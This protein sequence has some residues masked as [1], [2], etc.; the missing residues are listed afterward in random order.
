MIG[1]L[2]LIRRQVVLDLV[3]I[4]SSVAGHLCG[5][6]AGK[7]AGVLFACVVTLSTSG[8]T[9]RWTVSFPLAPVV[10]LHAAEYLI[11]WYLP[12]YTWGNSSLWLLINIPSLLC[13]TFSSTL[14]VLFPAVELP[15]IPHAVYGV[16]V[17]D[18]YIPMLVQQHDGKV[19]EQQLPA[20]LLYPTDT[21][22]YSGSIPY[23][24]IQSAKEFCLS[25]VKFGAPPPLRKH[26]WILHNWMLI[27]LRAVPDAPPAQNV[28]NAPF[29]VCSH[30]LGGCID[31]Y[32]YQL[33]ALTARLGAVVLTF[34]HMDGSA[35]CIPLQSG[36]VIVREHIPDKDAV[37]T[38]RKQTNVRV[39]ELLL[40]TDYVLQ[41]KDEEISNLHTVMSMASP[42]AFFMGHSFGA[43]TAIAAAHQRP[44]LVRGV[45]AH[46][47][48][49]DW[50]PDEART[51]F[52][53]P[54]RVAG[55]VAS[56]ETKPPRDVL[57]PP[58]K[59]SPVHDKPILV[60][61]SQEWTDKKWGMADLLEEMSN[62]KRLGQS[63]TSR[64]ILVSQSKHMEFSDL[65]MLN[66][67]WLSQ[68]VGMVGPR[69]PRETAEEISA[70]TISFIQDVN[71]QKV[72]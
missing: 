20:R 38:R 19:A 27:K 13:V 61:N 21:N 24:N 1:G 40:A 3:S 29:V 28:Q 15:P 54:D 37:Y 41:S 43:T 45:I 66:P 60:M 18:F 68:A 5:N 33:M 39:Q 51:G 10:L 67:N 64:H 48:V 25:S 14:T 32:S 36:D 12:S 35:S 57:T 62:K 59:A 46:E 44:G 23:L 2:R 31:I 63:E 26:P 9:K 71:K 56:L 50:I 34:T 55:L 52:L 58:T 7:S 69:V 16:G 47:P 70:H 30:G 4:A 42:N 53:F 22:H 65:G 11:Q 72:S 49:M 8:L 6:L 17:K